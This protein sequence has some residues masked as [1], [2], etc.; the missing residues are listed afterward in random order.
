VLEQIASEPLRAPAKAVEEPVRAV[1]PPAAIHLPPD[2]YASTMKEAVAALG[3]GRTTLYHAIAEGAV[4]AVKL[5]N[6]TL[7]PVDALR[8]GSNALPR[9]ER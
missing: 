5:G 2:K 7:I 3:V 4:P 8:S 6:L 1:P 9:K